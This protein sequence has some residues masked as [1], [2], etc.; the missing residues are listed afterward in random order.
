MLRIYL[1]NEAEYL[2]L[3][4]NESL[5]LTVSSKDLSDPV[6][7]IGDISKELSVPATKKNNN[8]FK[9]YH[10][11]DVSG[12][13]DARKFIQ[14]TCCGFEIKIDMP[15][16]ARQIVYNTLQTLNPLSNS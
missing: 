13:L 4:E 11:G 12:Q 6:K 5:E 9:H 16:S 3:Y 7:I 2:D 15:T 14:C 8:I 1:N 10:R